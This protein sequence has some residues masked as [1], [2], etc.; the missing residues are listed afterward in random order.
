MKHFAQLSPLSIAVAVSVVL[1]ALLLMVRFV[2]PDAFV[3][4]PPDPSLEVILVNA[5]H[6]KAPLKADALAQAN[7]EG[8][9]NADKGRSRSPLPDMKKQEIGDSVKAAQRKVQELEER[10]KN[11]MTQNKNSVF[12]APPVTEK[13]KPDPTPTGADNLTTSKA[14]ARTAAEIYERIED[15]NKRP[16]KTFFSPSTRAVGWAEYY[17]ELV[18]K[19]EEVGTLS[20]PQDKGKKLY[21][22]LIVNIPITQ[23]GA[24]YT[25][26]KD[27]GLRI[28]RSSG[29]A[30]LDKAALNIVR[31]SAPFGKF[32]GKMRATTDRD[33]VWIIILGFDF[34]R[35]QGL[36]TEFKGQ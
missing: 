28:E 29:N 5:K 10:Q 24:I 26:K 2:D 15:E 8:G 31:K 20:F 22:K 9:G 1:H 27:G 6:A 12:S 18:K 13:D 33:D 25:N 4:K 36:K 21:G 17:T 32:P 7:L 34:T 16:R 11:L 14:I 30:A 35:D 23:D 3:M 19:I